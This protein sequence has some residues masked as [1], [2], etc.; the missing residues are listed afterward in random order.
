MQ[1][2]LQTDVPTP[3]KLAE[4][5]LDYTAPKTE[6]D[7]IHCKSHITILHTCKSINIYAYIHRYR[8]TRNLGGKGGGANAPSIF[9]YVR[10]IFCY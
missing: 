6:D 3:P 4:I 5:L 7:N 8:H 2:F 1:D 9:F 10:I